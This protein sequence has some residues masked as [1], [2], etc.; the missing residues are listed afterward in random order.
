VT[1]TARSLAHLRKAGYIAA[2]VEKWVPQAKIRIDLFGCLDVL[3]VGHGHTVGIQCTSGS[4]ASS[5]LK[6]LQASDAVP[7][8]REAG[9]KIQVHAWRKSARSRRWE[10]REIELT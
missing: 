1:P 6:K 4:N 9:W 5:R 3:A 10:L 2:V 8:L 7:V